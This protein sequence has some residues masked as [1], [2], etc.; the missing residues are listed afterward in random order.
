MVAFSDTSSRLPATV[1]QI[2]G[3]AVTSVDLEQLIR[4]MKYT[5]RRGGGGGGGGG[6]HK[7]RIRL[8]KCT[9]NFSIIKMLHECST[10][11]YFEI[12]NES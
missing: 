7:E 6:A 11:D 9:N 4:L 10:T 5:R 2:F 8:L 12:R 1:S 3:G